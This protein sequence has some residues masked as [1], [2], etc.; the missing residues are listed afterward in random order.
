[1]LH[2]LVR[3]RPGSKR[4]GASWAKS[5]LDP[6]WSGLIDRAWA[7]RVNPAVTVKEPANPADYEATIRFLKVMLRRANGIRVRGS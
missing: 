6:E 3:R 2:D 5:V 7:G 1:M 4:E